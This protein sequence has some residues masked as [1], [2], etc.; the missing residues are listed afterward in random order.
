M[1]S[2]PY[3]GTPENARIQYHFFALF[4]APENARVRSPL[5]ILS[6]LFGTRENVGIT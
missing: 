5:L 2:S 1:I 4:W 3:W 6:P